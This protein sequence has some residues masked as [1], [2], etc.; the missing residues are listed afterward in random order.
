MPDPARR[1]DFDVFW[2]GQTLSALGDAFAFIAL[3]LLVLEITGSVAKMGLVTAVSG[4]AQAAVG[5]SSGALMDRV[6]RRRTMIVCDISRAVLFMLIPL[7][8]MTVGPS[9]ALVYV[10]TALGSALSTLFS[11]G[12]VTAI[13]SLVGPERVTEANGRLTASHGVCYVVGPALAGLVSARVGPAWAMGVDA[14]SFVASALTLATVRFGAARSAPAAGQADRGVMDGVR[15]LLRH[16]VLR[17]TTVYFSAIAILGA[18]VLD[19]LVFLLK[20]GMN[21]GDGTVG[22][23]MGL[24]AVGAVLGGLGAAPSRRRFGFGV[25]F[26]GAS[27]L[28][29]LSIAGMGLSQAGVVTVGCAAVWSAGMTLRGV[30]TMSLRQQITPDHLLGRVTATFWT[31]GFASAPLGAAVATWAAEHV[32][33][34]PVLVVTGT[35]LLLVTGLAGFTPLRFA[36]PESLVPETAPWPG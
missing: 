36:R 10:V 23:V 26:L 29:G 21:E 25:S 19:L 33:V 13:P 20:R 1:R 3:P 8:W 16:P 4:V 5:L 9:M 6:D 31:L 18:G 34:R 12:Y 35:L 11:V 7:G 15:F 14:L 30:V 22:V 28:Q 27:V 24:A 32:G 17:P 2:I